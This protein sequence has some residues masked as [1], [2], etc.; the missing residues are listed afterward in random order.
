TEIRDF[1]Y[2]IESQAA[3]RAAQAP[4]A[5][6]CKG[7]GW[8]GQAQLIE[9]P[10]AS[11]PVVDSHRRQSADIAAIQTQLFNL[12]I[13]AGYIEIVIELHVVQVVLRVRFLAFG[14]IA[15]QCQSVKIRLDPARDLAS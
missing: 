3:V 1:C 13:D 2:C 9:T 10:K 11:T 12:Q 5:R 15:S 4:H 6:T 8:T 7:G 14:L